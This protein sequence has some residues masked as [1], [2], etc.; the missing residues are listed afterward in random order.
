MTA[1][2][3]GRIETNPNVPAGGVRALLYNYDIESASL[4]AEHVA[5]L[6]TKVLPIVGK[7]P[8][9]CWLLGSA[10]ASGSTSYNLELSKARVE[11]VAAFL[12]GRG[13]PPD[14]ISTSFVGES[15]AK[16]N[17]PEDQIDRSVAVMSAPLLPPQPASPPPVTSPVAKRSTVFKIRELGGISAGFGSL[18]FDDIFFQSWDTTNNLTTFYFFSAGGAGAGVKGGPPVS[19]TLRGPWNDYKTTGPVASD[20]FGGASRFTTEGALWWS[21]NYVNFMQ[22][23]RGTATSPNPLSISTGFTVGAGAS[24]TVGTMTRGPTYAFSGP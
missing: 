23:P 16:P 3:P 4:K 5:F 1:T 10:S 2:G 15:R 6:T 19:V 22:M 8:S 20:E 11:G 9:R 13:V 14:R 7:S 12:T 17:A 24:S 18:T 21:T